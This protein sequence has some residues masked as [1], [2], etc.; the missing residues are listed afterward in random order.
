[1]VNCCVLKSCPN[2]TKVRNQNVGHPS[3]TFHR[4]PQ[5][6]EMRAL[7]LSAIKKNPAD[8]KKWTRICSFHFNTT[9]YH[10]QTIDLLPIAVPSKNLPRMIIN[11]C[12]FI[13]N[14]LIVYILILFN[15][16]AG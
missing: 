15:S 3:P 6:D 13:K 11:L 2:S 10:A 7:W 9:D 4:F 5:N 1:M 8:V 14:L 16:F 12:F